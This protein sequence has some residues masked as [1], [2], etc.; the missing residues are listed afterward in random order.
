MV[1][2]WMDAV[3]EPHH[4]LQEP[5]SPQQ[6][7]EP[8]TLEGPAHNGEK[9]G[10]RPELPEPEPKRR[11]GQD[12]ILAL[13]LPPICS[14][15]ECCDTEHLDTLDRNPHTIGDHVLMRYEDF[16]WHIFAVQKEGKEALHNKYEAIMKNIE[17]VQGYAAA[18]HHDYDKAKGIHQ[19]EGRAIKEPIAEVEGGLTGQI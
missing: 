10:D 14:T 18:L 9:W 16:Q 19:A 12:I 5:A 13:A 15:T 3:L 4:P 1:L 11:Q 6:P 7:T 8:S 2:L 17:G